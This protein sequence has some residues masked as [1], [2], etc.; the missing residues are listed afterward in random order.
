MCPQGAAHRNGD[1]GACL[2]DGRRGKRQK[3]SRQKREGGTPTSITETQTDP[4]RD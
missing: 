3:A 1:P 4:I 2:V